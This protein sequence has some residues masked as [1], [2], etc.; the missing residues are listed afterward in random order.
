MS[1]FS[2]DIAESKDWFDKL[3]REYNDFLKDKTS[4]DRAINFS[5]TAH[6]MNEWAKSELT[7]KEKA[8][9]ALKR[10]PVQN[11]FNIIQDLANGTK[12]KVLKY[13]ST[14]KTTEHS[15]GAFSSGFSRGFNISTLNIL[16]NSGEKIYFEDVAKNIYNF[17]KDYFN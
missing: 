7:E 4:S 15:R 12:H 9:L 13:E 3:E 11:D 6:H 14:I 1:T 16:M 2:F 10:K 5:I 17:W 8:K